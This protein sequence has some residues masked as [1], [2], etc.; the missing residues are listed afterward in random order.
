MKI[1]IL[2]PAILDDNGR[3]SNNLGDIIIQRAVTQELRSLFGACDIVRI[4]SHFRMKA[5]H[6][7]SI[8][9]SRYVFVG[10]SNLLGN[11][12]FNPCEKLLRLKGFRWRQWGLTLWDARRVHNAILLGAGW[13]RYEGRTGLY[14]RSILKAALSKDALH[15]VRDEYTKKKLNLIG[16]RNVV[17]TGCPTMWP[18]AK[19][20]PTTFPTEKADKALVMLTDTQQAPEL[21]AKLLELVL[22][23]YR[24]VFCW[25]QGSGDGDYAAS[26][27]FPI[28]ILEHSLK[29]LEDFVHGEPD[30]DYIGS[31]LHGGI[32]CM[33]AKKRSLILR[34]DNRAT[35]IS[36]DTGLA[37]A[38]RDD[39][40]FIAQWI[41]DSSQH[42]FRI[43]RQAINHW[44]NQFKSRC[45]G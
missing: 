12:V 31:R 21:D 7:N 20:D 22:A 38:V 41:D 40:D 9:D 35:E 25:P 17:N 44:R 11:S 16:I 14:T 36:R 27:G 29:A 2:D 39:F 37:T 6:F 33:G 24:H 23:K 5:E 32:Y 13:W 15:S 30:F 26:L 42:E 18:L 19:L 10:G 1:S 43:N 4:S 34:I 3:L 45:P 28:N 8:Q